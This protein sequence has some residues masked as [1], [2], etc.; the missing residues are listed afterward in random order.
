VQA[1]FG[2]VGAMV[3]VPATLPADATERGNLENGQSESVTSQA[4]LTSDVW[5][6][7]TDGSQQVTISVDTGS[8]TASTLVLIG[9]YDSNGKLITK[10]SLSSSSSN[11]RAYTL[12]ASL[13]SSGTYSILVKG[14]LAR[15]TIKV[16]GN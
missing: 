7:K 10:S 9:V 6:Y 14:V 12:S 13:P 15:Y 3:D 4:D 5:T 2:T 1:A 16:T 8:N 11:K